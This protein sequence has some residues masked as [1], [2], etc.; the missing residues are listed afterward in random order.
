MA[1]QKTWA[2]VIMAALAILSSYL[3]YDKYEQYKESKSGSSQSVEVHIES[4]PDSATLTKVEVERMI[5]KA[6]K[7]RHE[8]NLV[9]FKQKESWD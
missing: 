5:E 4:I 8:K 3:G 1:A 9:L 6:I 2:G 7:A